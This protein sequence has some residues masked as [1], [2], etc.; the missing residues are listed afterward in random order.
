MKETM[1]SASFATLPPVRPLGTIV[2]HCVAPRDA[3]RGPA[4]AVHCPRCDHDVTV[5][6]WA[7]DGDLTECCGLL[8]RISREGD[9]IWLEQI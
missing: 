9:A 5:P 4:G 7:R 1:M 8:L 2:P 6:P 3:A